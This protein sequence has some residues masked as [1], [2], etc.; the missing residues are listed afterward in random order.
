MPSDKRRN[1]RETDGQMKTEVASE[2]KVNGSDSVHLT[3]HR[4]LFGRDFPLK[5]LQNR[6]E[7]D[8]G[9]F[10]LQA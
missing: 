8:L 6:L 2:V 1:V 7:K 10:S 9:C 4:R 5:F 3:S